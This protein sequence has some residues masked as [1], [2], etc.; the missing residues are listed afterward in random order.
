MADIT[1]VRQQP[2]QASEQ[3]KE[4]ARRMIFGMVDGLGE[5]GRKQLSLI[6]I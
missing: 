3:E 6:H 2:V 1:L 5:R 4:A